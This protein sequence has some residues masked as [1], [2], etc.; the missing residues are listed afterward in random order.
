MTQWTLKRE[1][2]NSLL[3]THTGGETRQRMGAGSDLGVKHAIEKFSIIFHL[4]ET[5]RQL[6]ECVV[7]GTESVGLRRHCVQVG[8]S[9]AS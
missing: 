1:R 6:N 3:P 9:L 2:V 8:Q 5:A 4:Q 7:H